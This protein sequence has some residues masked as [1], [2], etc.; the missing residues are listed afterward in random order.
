VRREQRQHGD[1]A[2]NQARN[3]APLWEAKDDTVVDQKRRVVPA[4]SEGHDRRVRKR[5]KL[6]ADEPRRQRRIDDD[7]GAPNRLAHESCGA[8][9]GGAA[10]TPFE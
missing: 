10:R 6:R 5:R 8:L 7:I 1:L 2:F 9:A 4:V 3:D